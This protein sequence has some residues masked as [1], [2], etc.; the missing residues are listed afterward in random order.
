MGEDM[1]S[2]VGCRRRVHSVACQRGRRG[3][4]ARRVVPGWQ[5]FIPGR[6]WS[7]LPRGGSE[8]DRLPRLEMRATFT[9]FGFGNVRDNC[10]HDYWCHNI[11]Y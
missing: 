1:A 6:G 7:R 11:I 5:G 9:S 8:S 10:T 2:G 3:A 4:A